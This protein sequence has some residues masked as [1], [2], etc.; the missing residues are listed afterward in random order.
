MDRSLG[1]LAVPAAKPDR[2]ERAAVVTII[3]YKL[4]GYQ[5]AGLAI[6]GN[7]Q[8]DLLEVFQLLKY[9]RLFL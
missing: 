5:L 9:T 8:L 2:R 1:E 7:A 6:A 4:S 3:G